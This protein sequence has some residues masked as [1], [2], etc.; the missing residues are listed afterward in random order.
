MQNKIIMYSQLIYIIG[1]GIPVVLLLIR[2]H[3]IKD[4]RSKVGEG[5][6]SN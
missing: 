3:P 5:V 1:Y 4:V 2:D 6:G